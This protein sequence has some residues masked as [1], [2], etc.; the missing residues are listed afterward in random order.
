MQK[1]VGKLGKKYRI[2]NDLF[3]PLLIYDF[4]VSDAI[5]CPGEAELSS[6]Y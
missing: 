1:N 2:I 6:E 5:A 3:A 4:D